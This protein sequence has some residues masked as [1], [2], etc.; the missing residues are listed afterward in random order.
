MPINSIG[1]Q[2][3]LQIMHKTDKGDTL[4]CCAGLMIPRLGIHKSSL[5]ICEIVR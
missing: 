5:T 2:E 4:D 3:R 1:Y